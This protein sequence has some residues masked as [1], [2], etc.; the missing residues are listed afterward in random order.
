M[1][2]QISKDFSLKSKLRC[3]ADGGKVSGPG[4]PTD[5][6]A[7]Q[8]ALSDGEYV[9]PADTVQA[10]GKDKLDAI[11]EATHKH[12]GKKGALRGMANG[13]LAGDEFTRSIQ[14]TAPPAQPAPLRPAVNTGAMN[15]YLAAK[16]AAGPA[17]R[18]APVAEGAPG[19]AARVGGGA[20]RLAGNVVS[21]GL[22][23]VA[24][25]VGAGQGLAEN[26]GDG[27][28]Q[29]NANLGADSPLGNAAADTASVL[30]K[31]GDAATFGYASKLG[32]GISNMIGGGNFSDG[33]SPALPGVSATP[34]AGA[35][36]AP[37][38]GVG[39]GGQNSTLRTA[40]TPN[41]QNLGNYGGSQPVFGKSDNGTSVINNFTDAA[42]AGFA[43]P[44]G[45]SPLRGNTM[46]STPDAAYAGIGSEG[47]IRGALQQ[48]AN[49]SAGGAQRSNPADQINQHFDNLAKQLNGTY[50]GM[51][52]GNLTKHLVQL[53]SARANA[54]EG[55][56]RNDVSRQNALTSADTARYGDDSRLRTAGQTQA[57]ELA[58]FGAQQQKDAAANQE[59]GYSRFQEA[60][61][62]MFSVPSP[63]GKGFIQD[64]PAQEKFRDFILNSDPKKVKG[65][66]SYENFLGM[67]PQEQQSLLAQFKIQNQMNQARNDTSQAGFFNSGKT[68]NTF[69]PAVSQGSAAIDDVF[70]HNLPI[71]DYAVS[72]LRG[73]TPGASEDPIVQTSSGQAV[74]RSKLVGSDLDRERLLEEQLKTSSLRK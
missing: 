21:K 45:G 50:S 31:I 64:A 58:K 9:L 61:K 51:G 53:E 28:D 23:P 11:K 25:V 73:I 15:D 8:F 18:A 10:I 41:F 66:G 71:S 46:A 47:L 57:L 2:S 69:D 13:G 3:M 7:G 19:L 33:A 54:L 43:A 1:K 72:K 29:R 6:E 42:G 52:R 38:P 34:A 20:L 40:G 37:I 59:K 49:A 44:A 56:D 16:E 67:Q 14:S 26:L 70:N 74:R 55:I 5:D 32:Q 35:L 68:T 60:V 27:R 63:D 65:A 12:V 24:G 17:A 39:N 48:Q 62:G 36:P 30:G 4:G 22:L